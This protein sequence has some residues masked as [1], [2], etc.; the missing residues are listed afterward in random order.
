MRIEI[1][2]D[3]YDDLF[4]DFDARNYS[5]RYFSSDF[6]GE[7][8]IRTHRYRSERT[9]DIVFIIPKDER[10]AEQEALIIQRFR[11][12]VK[13]RLKRNKN[14]HKDVIVKALAFESLG[15]LL[16]VVANLISGQIPE[17]FKDFLLIPSWFFVWNGLERY[18]INRQAIRAKFRYYSTLNESSYAFAEP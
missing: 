12:F 7:L 5:D 3:N 11:K 2:I 15:I 16:L 14:K 9:L 18:L 10:N 6:L 17:L 1:A 13:N 8:K 4:S